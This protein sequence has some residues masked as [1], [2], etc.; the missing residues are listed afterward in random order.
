MLQCAPY[1]GSAN[2]ISAMLVLSEICKK[3]WNKYLLNFKIW[4]II[5]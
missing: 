2:A 1:V 3:I 4:Y 5:Y